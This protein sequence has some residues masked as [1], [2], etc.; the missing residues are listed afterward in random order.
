MAVDAN[1]GRII[2]VSA[3]PYD[4]HAVEEMLESLARCGVRHVEPAFIVGYTEPFDETAWEAVWAGE[5]DTARVKQ[6]TRDRATVIRAERKA[7]QGLLSIDPS[8]IF[9]SS[10]N[11]YRIFSSPTS[12]L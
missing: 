4:G 12:C 7:I 8:L 5:R 2:S 1:S 10:A 11:S 3:A 9:R 6:A